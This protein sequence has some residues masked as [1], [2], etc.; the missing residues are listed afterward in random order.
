[1]LVAKHKIFALVLASLF[2]IGSLSLMP[3]NV[4]ASHSFEAGVEGDNIPDNTHVDLSGLTLPPL[5]VMPIYDSSPN[6]ISGHFLYRASCDQDTHEPFVSVIAGH[7]DESNSNTHVDFVPLFYIDAASTAGS[8]VYHAHIPD[9]I[10]GGSP[11]NT[12][13]DLINFSGVDQT[14]N[15][16]DAADMNVQRV[17]GSIGQFYEGNV[18]LPAD[19]AGGNNPIFDLNPQP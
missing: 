16:G 19:L 3:L 13:I 18:Q 12:D 14:F 17:L 9:P 10:N 1:M 5:G 2:S 6:F 4:N 7:I 8:C 11:R 15:P